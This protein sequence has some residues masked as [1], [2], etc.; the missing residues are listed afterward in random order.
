[1][2][3]SFFLALLVLVLPWGYTLEGAEQSTFYTLATSVALGRLFRHV[4]LIPPWQDKRQESDMREEIVFLVNR[5]HISLKGL[6]LWRARYKAF[7]R[8]RHA[9][10]KRLNNGSVQTWQQR[11]FF[12]HWSLFSLSAS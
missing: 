2:G 5:F 11:V 3:M 12:I 10:C 8:A 7:L 9:L 1:M 6:S 4:V